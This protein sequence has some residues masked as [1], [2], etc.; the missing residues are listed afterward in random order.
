MGVRFVHHCALRWSDMDAYGHVNNTRFLTLY[1]EA[2][3]AFIYVLAKER[4]GPSLV[5]DG[6]VIARHE[7]DYLR[8]VVYRTHAS[9]APPPPPHVRIELWTEKVRGAQ[10]TVAYE[11]FDGDLL[12][13]RARTVCV[14]FDLAG[15]RPRRMTE[16]ERDFLS[17]YEVAA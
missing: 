12:A 17:R 16:W 6:T 2:R 4:G 3:V 15:Q 8:P 9:E 5:D 11:L 13:S 1:E 10:F 7:I 14:L